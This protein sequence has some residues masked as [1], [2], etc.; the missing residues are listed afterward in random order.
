M[1]LKHTVDLTTP[2]LLTTLDALLHY[3]KVL[4]DAGVSD[5]EMRLYHETSAAVESAVRVE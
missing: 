1:T 2:Q 4:M 5:R 3:G